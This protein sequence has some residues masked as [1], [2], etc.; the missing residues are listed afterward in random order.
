MVTKR[1][2]A[3]IKRLNDILAAFGPDADR[4]PDEERASLVAL[5]R[6]DAEAEGLLREAEALDRVMALAP[7]GNPSAGLKDRIVAA[8]AADADK[9]ARI[10]PISAA[11]AATQG[12]SRPRG[13]YWEG[14]ALAASFV[15]GLYLGIA[16]AC[17][18]C[19]RSG[20]GTGIAR[21]YR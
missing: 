7:A 18:Y 20:H 19:S 12:R 21:G 5:A 9:E 4:W 14:V 1:S 3:Q 11:R 15:L 10:V 17:E 2:S 13:A 16:G 6:S 8:A